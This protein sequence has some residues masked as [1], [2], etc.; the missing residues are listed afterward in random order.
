[1]SHRQISILT[2]ILLTASFCLFV[3]GY[4][5]HALVQAQARVE[6]HARIIED[7]MWN[8]NH[9]GASE[10]LT[11]AADTY[12]YESLT[13]THHNGDIFQEIRTEKPGPFESFLIRLHLIP[14][15]PLLAQVEYRGNIIGWVEATW[16]PRWIYVFAYVFF[17]A[18]LVYIVIFLYLRVLKA[19]NVMEDRVQERT[20]ELLSSNRALKREIDDH[21]IA[22]KALRASEEQHRL[23]AANISP[24]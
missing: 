11:L 2:A 19:K 5:K 21:A 13:V 23:L 8:Y 17:A 12:H 3:V 20:T 6:T 9:L 14:R 4:E 1:M 16:L 10:Y 22:E 7:A 15:V 18:V 24:M